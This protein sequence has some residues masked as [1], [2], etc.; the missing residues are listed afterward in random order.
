MVTATFLVGVCI[1]TL[2]HT[3][4]LRRK[5]VCFNLSLVAMG[6]IIGCGM[7]FITHECL[8]QHDFMMR[9]IIYCLTA[10][11]FFGLIYL[12]FATYQYRSERMKEALRLAA[13]RKKQTDEQLELNHYRLLT[14]QIQPHFIFNTLGNLMALVRTDPVRAEMLLEAFIS[15]LQ[16]V[17]YGTRC[18]ELQIASEI[19]TVEAYLAIQAIRTPRLSYSINVPQEMRHVHMPPLVLLTLVENAMKHGI[20]KRPGAG[21][22]AIDGAINDHHCWIEVADDGAGFSGHT[23]VFVETSA[24]F[25][26]HGIGLENVRKR[27]VALYGKDSTLTLRPNPNQGCIARIVMPFAAGIPADITHGAN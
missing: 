2:I 13:V 19:E 6:S 23:P 20:N 17:A 14:A 8:M 1:Q 11:P 5:S 21:H 4:G 7:V 16:N 24:P 3:F 26:K 27:L 10:G 25:A 12:G 9:D 18:C 15:Y 22:I